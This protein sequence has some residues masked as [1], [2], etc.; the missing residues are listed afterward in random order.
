ME[1]KMPGKSRR[2]IVLIGI[3]GILAIAA[4]FRFWD[5]YAVEMMWDEIMDV[6][7]ALTYLETPNPFA[8]NE[9]QISEEVLQARLPYYITALSLYFTPRNELL[10]FY[11]QRARIPAALFGLLTVLMVYLLGKE[12]YGT[13]TG[14][15]SALLLAISSYHIGF[16]RFAVT[17]GESYDPFF[18][19]LSLLLFFKGITKNNVK[20]LLLSGVT[21][22]LACACKFNAALLLP[23]FFLFITVGFHKE[24]SFTGTKGLRRLLLLNT[25]AFFVFLLLGFFWHRLGGQ[26]EVAGQLGKFFLA[27][28]GI[29]LFML[30][31]IIYKM[32]R[33]FP[34][35][36]IAVVVANIVLMAVI[37]G[38]IGSPLHLA[39]KNLTYLL[40]GWIPAFCSTQFVLW[41]QTGVKQ[42]L[43]TSPLNILLIKLGLPFNLMFI[44]GLIY[45]LF[46]LKNRNN[47]LISLALLVYLAVVCSL[48]TFMSWYL[49]LIMP[50]A[51][52]VSVNFL[53]LCWER[54]RVRFIRIILVLTAFAG[55]CFQLFT[56]VRITPYYHFDGY[57]LGSNF[58][59]F[60]KP[61]FLFVTDGMKG[62]IEWLEQN[63]PDN[64]RVGIGCSIKGFP[65]HIPE[66]MVKYI[67]AI[68]SANPT[69][70][71]EYIT[72]EKSLFA[73]DYLIVS[74]FFGED[75]TAADTAFKQIQA[76]KICGV[77]VYKVYK[78][79]CK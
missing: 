69:I 4:V 55:I 14:L 76:Q 16:S 5:L 48:R 34:P 66:F 37:V 35:K 12:L 38:F 31:V 49:M 27:V 41:L 52:M 51:I 24:I 26:S 63:I 50:L 22:G 15:I 73:F 71:Y 18:Y 25:G 46:H 8:L 57:K 28:S 53:V 33:P 42:A 79:I 43:S 9:Q 68:Y 58:I 21:T 13:K 32:E 36:A 11:V 77:T 59:G 60:N 17:Q 47:L 19:L 67:I 65:S 23:A 3:L 45:N 20:Y 54:L 70:K 56:L 75:R 74:A 10:D 7:V 44:G 62:S 64:S 72:N 30:F 1:K 2:L 40:F 6:P 39:P 61:C 78:N 29:Y